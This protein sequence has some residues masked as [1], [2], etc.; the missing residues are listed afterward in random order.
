MDLTKQSKAPVIIAID[1]RSGAGKTTLAGRVA[2]RLG[3]QLIHM[4]AIYPGWEGLEEGAR[5]AAEFIVEPLARG[6]DAR[7]PSWDWYAM[8]PG[9]ELRANAGLPVVLEGC[10]SITRATAPHLSLGVWLELDERERRRRAEQRGGTTDEWW[11]GWRE[12]EERL[13]TRERPWTRADVVLDAALREEEL[14]SCVWR[15]LEQ[16]GWDG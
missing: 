16:R 13:F 9:A 12:Q 14:L 4:D 11:S 7:C 5:V 2:E 15:A 6:E 1:G 8:R 10:G 3:A